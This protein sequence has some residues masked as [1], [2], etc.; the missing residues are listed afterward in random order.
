[1]LPSKISCT[2]SPLTQNAF[3]G[4]SLPSKFL[5]AA[6]IYL[7]GFLLNNP[8]PQCSTATNINW[9]I[10]SIVKKYANIQS[11]VLPHP[12]NDLSVWG[13]TKGSDYGSDQNASWKKRPNKHINLRNKIVKTL[14]ERG[15][16]PLY[17]D[18]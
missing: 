15:W 9:I 14:I 2:N 8:H 1:M 11:Y 16:K 17:L 13:S 6:H 4:L 5:N 10:A 12:K 3:S 7:S 18:K